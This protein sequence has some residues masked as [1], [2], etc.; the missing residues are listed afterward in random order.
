[1]KNLDLKEYQVRQIRFSRLRKLLRDNFSDILCGQGGLFVKTRNPS[2]F[3]EFIIFMDLIGLPVIQT[4]GEEI[5][6]G[7]RRGSRFYASLLSYDGGC[8]FC[9]KYQG[10]PD[11]CSPSRMLYGYALYD[12]SE[13]HRLIRTHYCPE[14]RKE[15]SNQIK[16]QA[17]KAR[18]TYMI[19]KGYIETESSYVDSKTGAIY[20][21]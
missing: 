9:G 4:E 3:E 11:I 21:L 17:K 1:V 8:D 20:P 14:C 6:F 10:I 5:Q 13:L 18:K 12:D 15:V 16:E 7:I 19:D 2:A